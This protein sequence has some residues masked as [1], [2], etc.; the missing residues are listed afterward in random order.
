MNTAMV[1]GASWN[2]LLRVADRGI[3]LLST[4]V[5]ARLLVPAD[6]GLVALAT[7]LIALLALLGDFGF[8]LALIQNP[9][10]HRDHFDSVWTFNVLFG[11]ALA[12]LLALIAT[13]AARFYNDPRLVDVLFGLAVARAI[14]CFENVGV[15]AFRKDL[16]FDQEFR[17]LIY[18]RL[19]TTFLVT[20]PLA[21]VLRSYWALVGGMIAGSCI[22][23]VLSYRLHP[24]RPR[25]SLGAM[26]ELF[27]FSKW[28]QVAHLVSFVSARA[29]DFIIGKLAGISVLGSFT[30]AKE[31][32]SLPS[33]EVAMPVHRGVFPS[34]AKLS[35]D[36]PAL[37]RAYLRVASVLVLVT[38]PAGIGLALVAQPVVLIFLGD[39]WREVVPLIQ[40]LA[41][42]GVLSVSSTTASYIYLALGTPRR[43]A[44]L[45]M[46]HAGVSLC[47]MLI[48][49]PR[50]GAQGAAYALLAGSLVTVPVNFRMMSNAVRL[51]MRDIRGIVWRPLMST[52]AM[53]VVVMIV[54]ECWMST[55]TLAG[56]VAN[57][58][59]AAG[60]G[61]V[62]YGTAM[63]LLWRLASRPEGAETFVLERMRILAAT[64]GSRFRLWLT[65]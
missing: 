38:L 45:T 22:G 9:N 2:V 8:D 27:S 4:V 16:A 50:L 24:Y 28:L 61:A 64:F 21:F 57:L 37:K 18:K 49:V 65:K 25:F 55:E 36:L 17:F 44:L 29:A 40:I 47:L 1:R 54:R 60:M 14:S 56:N 62:T 53:I 42:Q 39:K 15:I 30:I 26:R 31:I 43:N 23:L 5:L 46:I 7:S 13:S 3:G 51:T 35:G 59:T 10:A 52:I 19:A 33:A 12:A 34:Y 11:L 58:A 20:I 48:L 63:L 41:V 32:A 6:F